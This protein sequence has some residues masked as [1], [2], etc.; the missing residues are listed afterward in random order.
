MRA[1]GSS[2]ITLGKK[3][4]MCISQNVRVENFTSQPFRDLHKC[5][6]SI[7]FSASVTYSVPN[8]AGLFSVFDIKDISKI[9][10]AGRFSMKVCNGKFNHV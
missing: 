2:H 6:G 4:N 9:Q 10:T 1:G 3:T 7:T 5:V 8:T